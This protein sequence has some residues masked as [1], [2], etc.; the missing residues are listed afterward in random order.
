MFNSTHTL[1]GFVLA[2]TGLNGWVPRATVTAVIASNLPDVDI[3]TQFA[4]TATYL[5]HHRGWTHSIPGIPLLSLM[6]A[7]IMSR[8]KSTNAGNRRQL[9]WKYFAVALIVMATHP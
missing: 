7:A 1:V 3:V 8:S 9:F 5:D 2:R 6:L 4:G